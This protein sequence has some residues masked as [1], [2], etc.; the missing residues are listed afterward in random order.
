MHKQETLTRLNEIPSI[1]APFR[2]LVADRGAKKVIISVA[3]CQAID[4]EQQILDLFSFAQTTKVI[5]KELR[6]YRSRSVLSLTFQE[7]GF[8]VEL[9]LVDKKHVKYKVNGNPQDINCTHLSEDKVF[10]Q[11]IGR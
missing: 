2:E 6:F 9:H 8:R 1:W 11:L 7:N 10:L 5:F 3:N 4:K